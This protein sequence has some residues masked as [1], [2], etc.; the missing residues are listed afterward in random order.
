MPDY[1]QTS[2]L[3]NHRVSPAAVASSPRE[4]TTAAG[5]FRTREGRRTAL[6]LGLIVAVA[7]LARL[8]GIDF[9]LP[10]TQARP[11]ETQVMDVTLAYLR[12]TMWPAFYDYPRIYTYLL[13]TLYLGYFAVGWVV[14][15]FGSVADLVA[16]WP[17]HWEPFFLI[18][19]G[20]SAAC[21]IL[22][23]PVVY[24][25]GRRLG[26]RA[27]GVVAALFMSVAFLHVRDSHFGSTDTALTLFIVLSVWQML[28]SEGPRPGRHD[29]LAAVFAGLATAT[30]YNGL[31]LL[32]PLGL[33][34]LR[35]VLDAP[36][37]RLKA[38]FDGRLVAVGLAFGASLLVGVPFVLF[39]YA[40]F[41]AHMEMLRASMATGVGIVP[42]DNGW[43]YHLAVSLRHGI[44]L[45]LLVGAL[46]GMAWFSVR[47]W[48]RGLLFFS[49]PLA[50]FAVA[51]GM[52]NLF[53][54]YVIPVV[55]FACVAAAVLA[56]WCVAKLWRGRRGEAVVT[57]LAAVL[58]VAP[59][60]RSTMAIDRLL[61]RPDNRVVAT[62]W[63]RAHA[64]RGGSILQSG[65]RYGYAQFHP[66]LG[67]QAWIW[68]GRR[69]V[70]TFNRAPVT[71]TPDWILFQESQLPSS[72]QP[73]VQEL[74]ANGSYQL[75]AIL[76]AYDATANDSVYDRQD[77]FY[78]P[79]AG[80]DRVRRAGPNFLIYKRNDVAVLYG[81]PA[82]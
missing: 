50:Y 75:V 23:V 81:T 25:L 35:R 78:L 28:L 71:T 17:V 22:T 68:D 14:G 29:L 40:R 54:R 52:K 27:S 7:A 3:E 73:V 70:F 16:S 45:P 1:E 24:L 39:D 62:E 41:A 34:H 72:T 65:S 4:V 61:A 82:H 18:N 38:L 69:G 60:V 30:K 48:R 46:A 49:F 42:S 77:A 31:I 56:V 6:V 21:G 59:S 44:G 11:D 32:L 47:D 58:V 12:G 79:V 15:W 64:P 9:G 5:A 19:R 8:W 57:A 76:R 55:P 67:F 2:V 74:L 51:G 13:T 66:T 36:G 43:W 33:L 37:G 20:L 10:H 26:G 53:V 63:F 80:F